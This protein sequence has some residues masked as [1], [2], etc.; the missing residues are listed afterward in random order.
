MALGKRNAVFAVVVGL[1]SLRAFACSCPPPALASEF[2]AAETVVLVE[3]VSYQYLSRVNPDPD[4]PSATLYGERVTVRVVKSWK[5]K[6][7]SGDLAVVENWFPTYSCDR[8][9]W[10]NDPRWLEFVEEIPGSNST[11][12]PPGFFDRWILFTT[13]KQPW[14]LGGACGMSFPA[15][16]N[17]DLERQLDQLLSRQRLPQRAD[18][19]AENRLERP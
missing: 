18:P 13:H 17:Q 3:T 19:A 15:D 12:A 2:S 9:S 8:K 16:P 10:R 4:E 14:S 11:P 7:R 1:A 6:Y 5:G